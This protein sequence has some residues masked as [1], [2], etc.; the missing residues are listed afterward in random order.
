MDKYRELI[1]EI[2]RASDAITRLNLS[3]AELAAKIESCTRRFRMIMG[4]AYLEHLENDNVA[5]TEEHVR[6]VGHIAAEIEYAASRNDWSS[7]LDDS[8]R[9]WSALPGEPTT[10]LKPPKKM[11]WERG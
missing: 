1:L 4:P 6:A 10:T 5:I 11:T 8:E 2:G 3:D 9:L 7:V